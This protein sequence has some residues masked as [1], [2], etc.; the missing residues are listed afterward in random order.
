MRKFPTITIV[1]M[2]LADTLSLGLP[3]PVR[4]AGEIR[5]A[6]ETLRALQ[7]KSAGKRTPKRRGIRPKATQT[8]Q[9]AASS[10]AASCSINLTTHFEVNAATVRQDPRGQVCEISK[11][12]AQLDLN[13]HR[14][15]LAGHTVS[16][17]RG[18]Y[19]QNLSMRRA[20]AVRHL[21]IQS[22]RPDSERLIG[23]GAEESALL[24]SPERTA[25]DFAKNRR[26]Q[27]PLQPN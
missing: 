9:P 8:S 1:S 4:A 3:E 7:S 12:L 22:H 27:L 10:S 26:V 13:A 15:I 5:S 25:A 18:A 20:A 19:N 21:L 17:A 14:V 2:L 24:V 11:A 6:N 23:I 16:R